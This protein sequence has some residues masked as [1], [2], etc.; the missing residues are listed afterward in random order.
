VVFSGFPG[1][2]VLVADVFHLTY[3][4]RELRRRLGRTVLTA[5]GLALG[6]GLVIAII[7]VSQGLDD[8]QGAVL[9]PL[10]SVGTDILVSR[11]AGA[12]QGT[13]GSS[14]STTVAEPG[15]G[16]FFGRRNG[17]L[18]QQDTQAL[19][20]EN[21]NVVTDLAKLGKPGDKFTRDFFLSATLVSFPQDAVAQIDKLPGVSSSVGG[22]VQLAEHQTGTVPQIVASIQTGGQTFSQTVRPA[23]MTD[24][25]RQAFRQ[26]LQSKGVQLGQ[27]GAGGTGGG[28]RGGGGGGGGGFGGGGGNPAFDDC[29]PARFREFRAQFTT[30]LQTIRQVVDPPS[31]DISSQSYT[32]AGIDPADPK[33]GLVTDE[34]LTEGRW[35]GKG[36]SDEVLL[37]VAYANTKSLHVGST[38]P[39]NGTDYKVVG[40]VRPT[41]TGS[42]ADVYF[43]LSTLQKLAGKDGRVTQ[44]LVKADGSKDVGAVAARIKTLLP[45]AEVVTTAALAGQVSGSLADAHDLANRL[46]GALAV[47]VL[48]A[49]FAIAVLLTLSSIG[50]RVREIGTLRAIGWSKARVVRQLVGESVGIALIGG[51]VGV[52]FGAGIAALVHVLSP[53]LT[54]TTAGVPG[55]AGSPL[56]QLFGQAASAAH[57]TR[58]TLSAPL[59]PATLLLGVAFALVGGLLAGAVGGWRAARLAP[60]VALRNLG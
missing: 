16:G 56:S 19:L 37:N 8:A 60:A 47:I 42:T 24:A 39:I 28:F 44:V 38:L 54:A 18:N 3:L 43:P 51:V 59:H 41:L 49:A 6:V 40:L 4:R 25:E 22:L 13:T 57:T 5:L 34:Q 20:A 10:S 15:G 17:G 46:G 30:P 58:V 36:A 23:P 14:T 45:G 53:S 12:P 11:V 26:C 35:L 52:A 55:L 27:G 32:A 9:A 2:G 1:D 33:V 29:L 50:K 21:Q 31:T 48:L 7:G